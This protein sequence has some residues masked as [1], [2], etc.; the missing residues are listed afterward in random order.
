MVNALEAVNGRV[1]EVVR[2]LLDDRLSA[3]KEREFAAL[4]VDLGELLHEDADQRMP[5]R[6]V[7][8]S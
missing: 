3:D 6:W 4:L 5:T 7:V 2:A 8:G 1:P